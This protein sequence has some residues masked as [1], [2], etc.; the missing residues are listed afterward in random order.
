MMRLPD[1]YTLKARIAPVLT[2]IALPALSALV[3]VSPSNPTSWF[4]APAAIVALWAFTSLVGRGRGKSLEKDLFKKWGGSP[5][6]KMLRYRST[7][8]PREQLAMLHQHF[9]KATFIRTPDEIF[10]QHVMDEAD[11]AYEAITR[12][13]RD[14]TRDQK[15]FPLVFDE[16]CNYGYVRNLFG[17][18]PLGGWTGIAGAIVAAGYLFAVQQSLLDL[19]AIAIALNLVSAITWF[20]WPTESSVRMV[21]E[22]YA[23]KLVSAALKI[24]KRDHVAIVSEAPVSQEAGKI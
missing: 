2:I 11:A 19:R 8:L 23:D 5:T 6:L 12:H 18:R 13:M 4:A 21:A 22:S 20:S 9:S 16:L 17:L 10:E 7:S 15:E 1:T 3:F 14:E 24:V